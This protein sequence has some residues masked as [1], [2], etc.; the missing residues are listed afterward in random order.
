MSCWGCCCGDFGRRSRFDFEGYVC[1]GGFRPLA[2]RGLPADPG[3]GR[4]F[5]A[6]P[7]PR[8]GDT[9]SWRVPLFKFASESDDSDDA[10]D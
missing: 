7:G 6:Q 8:V 4:L 5:D 10:L 9:K 3:A 2:P 1:G